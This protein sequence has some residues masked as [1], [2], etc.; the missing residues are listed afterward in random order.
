MS[1]EFQKKIFKKFKS[2]P[3]LCNWLQYYSVEVWNRIG[4]VRRTKS[5]RISETTITENLIFEFWKL[6]KAS[7][8]P[9]QIYE[10][11][12]ERV[13]GSDLEIFVET[14]KGFLFLPC[15]AKILYENDKYMAINHKVGNNEQIQ[16]LIDYADKMN[17]IPFYLLYNFSIDKT[18]EDI[19]SKKTLNFDISLYGCSMIGAD[20]INRYYRNGKTDSSGNKHWL[21][22][23]FQNLNPI[24]SFPF[25]SL[26]CSLQHKGVDEWIQSKKM[27]IGDVRPLFYSHQ[28]FVKNDNWIDLAPLPSIGFVINENA[29]F[30]TETRN[31][32]ELSANF[33]PQYRIVFPKERRR[34]KL[35]RYRG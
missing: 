35:V 9:I 16:L 15:Q 13:N 10:A 28:E 23:K 2:N 31:D 32:N 27:L 26:I 34:N 14:D 8:F 4:F 1:L 20:F 19:L 5:G 21:I 22:P 25:H 17:G 3:N 29:D 18:S 30:I 33:N 12:N 7:R 6:A 24:P 11:K